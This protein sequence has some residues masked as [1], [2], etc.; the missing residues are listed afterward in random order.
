MNTFIEL[1]TLLYEEDPEKE[2]L[3]ID[4]S[5]NEAVEMC[6]FNV[7]HIVSIFPNDDQN[8]ETKIDLING[9]RAIVHLPY[10]KVKERIHTQKANVDALLGVKA[11]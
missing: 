2:R 5:L 6:L 9:T 11:G 8:I 4:G 1:P 3:G 10:E 7:N